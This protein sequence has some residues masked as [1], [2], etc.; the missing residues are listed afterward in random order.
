VDKD[1]QITTDEIATT[2]KPAVKKSSAAKP[3]VKKPASSKAYIWFILLFIM[4]VV[5]VGFFQY[6]LEELIK[7]NS[8][9]T[10]HVNILSNQT[11]KQLKNS[12][13]QEQTL[14]GLRVQ[15]LNMSQVVDQIPGAKLNDWKLA[16]VEYL[17]RLANQRVQLQHELLAAKALFNA[18]D[19]ILHE[20]DDPALI[21]VR[22]QIAHEMLLL[23]QSNKFDRQGAYNQIQAIKVAVHKNIQPPEDYK[24]ATQAPVLKQDDSL[25]GQLKSLVTIRYRDEAFDA[26]LNAEQYLLLEH[27]L[28]LMLEQAQWALLKA[29]Q[30]LF[31]SSLKN[32]TQWIDTRLRHSGA[33]DMLDE[34]NKI[35]LFNVS[36]S[37]PN[38]SQSL[39]LLRQVIENRTYQPTALKG[40][41]TTG[42][43][44]MRKQ[45]VK[46]KSLTTNNKAE[47]I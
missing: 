18:A 22:Q 42:K 11:Q 4:L 26:P 24:Q 40:S 36:L 12:T 31:D 8:A 30:S 20:L 27:S 21:S 13:L 7:K 47:S 37:I 33:T 19:K 45:P 16:E 23:G 1:A 38:V 41:S 34:I 9:L 46:N 17:L 3:A 14:A 43:Q 10:E 39:L 29:D 2:K 44:K 5:S 25:L 6:R 35:A 32:A 15:V 28:T